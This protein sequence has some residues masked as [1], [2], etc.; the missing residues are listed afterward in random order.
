MARKLGNAM[1]EFERVGY[2]R[3]EFLLGIKLAGLDPT[4]HHQAIE[5]WYQV[6][7]FGWGD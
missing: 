2:N 4:G 6:E 1:G 5:A 3:N 7:Y